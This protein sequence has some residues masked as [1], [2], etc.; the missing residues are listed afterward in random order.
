MISSRISV[1]IKEVEELRNKVQ[2]LL[3]DGKS[4]YRSM[5]Y[6]QGI[7]DAIDWLFGDMQENPM[8]DDDAG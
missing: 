2:E 7:A 6:E 8:E 4:K 3:D 1:P 5:S